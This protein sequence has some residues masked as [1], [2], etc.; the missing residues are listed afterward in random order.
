M[1]V[2]HDGLEVENWTS[3]RGNEMHRVHWADGTTTQYDGP[4]AKNWVKW[5]R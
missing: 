2:E 3:K 4:L 1:K 5:N